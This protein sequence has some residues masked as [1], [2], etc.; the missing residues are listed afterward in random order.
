MPSIPESNKTFIT[1][2]LGVNL[3]SSSN[4][5]PLVFLYTVFDKR[6]GT[7]RRGKNIDKRT[8][9]KLFI[10]KATEE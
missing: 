4:S 9:G 8:T 3:G 7:T 5:T 10:L 6:N 1:G 2:V